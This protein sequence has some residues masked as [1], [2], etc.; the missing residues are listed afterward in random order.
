MEKQKDMEKRTEWFRQ[1]AF[2]MFIHWG[3]CSIPARGEWIMFQEQIPPE[4]YK[5][6]AQ[7]FNPHR[8]NPEEWVELAKASGCF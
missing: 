3:V 8:Y 6:L 1:A 5:L 4:E 7:R 2:G